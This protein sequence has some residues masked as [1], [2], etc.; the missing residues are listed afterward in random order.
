M[1][2]KLEIKRNVFFF[3]LKNTIIFLA[4]VSLTFD[5]FSPSHSIMFKIN[6]CFNHVQD[7]HPVQMFIFFITEHSYPTKRMPLK[8]ACT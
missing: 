8:Q 4:R 5:G 6:C 2:C 1:K 7:R 3:K